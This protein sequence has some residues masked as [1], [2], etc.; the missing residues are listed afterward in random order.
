M[1]PRAKKISK[2]VQTNPRKATS[3]K[4]I[5]TIH[6]KRGRKHKV[7]ADKVATS[8]S[9]LS[10]IALEPKIER[11]KVEQ[12][13]PVEPTL[14]QLG[15]QLGLSET[16]LEK[17]SAS[18]IQKISDINK[19]GGVSSLQGLSDLA[20]QRTI[21]KLE[22]HANLITI[23]PDAQI[24]ADLIDAGFTNMLQIVDTA[25]SKFVKDV[26]EKIGQEKAAAIHAAASATTGFLNSILTGIRA[27]RVN[28]YARSEDSTIKAVYEI[29]DANGIDNPA[30]CEPCK[31]AVSPLAYLNDLLNYA[32]KNI[33]NNNQPIDVAFLSNTFHQPFQELLDASCETLEEKVSQVRICVEVLRRELGT[34]EGVDEA[35]KSYVLKAY[36]FLLNQIGTSYE[37]IRLAY[38]ADAEQQ[39][40][41]ANRLGIDPENLNQLHLEVGALTEEMLEKRF[42]LQSTDPSRKPLT[43]RETPD[44]QTW[45][46]AHLRMLW[47]EQDWPSDPYFEGALPVIDPDI[48]GQYDIRM[49]RVANGLQALYNFEEGSGNTIYDISGIGEA[50]NLQV[51][52]AS[53]VSWL[54][55]G[56]L[57]IKTPTLLTSAGPANKI[58]DACR[59]TNEMTIETWVKPAAGKPGTATH[60]INLSKDPANC[61]FILS[62]VTKKEPPTSLFEVRLQTTQTDSI[63]TPAT[64]TADGSAKPEL[65]HVVYIRRA[66]G[67]VKIYLNDVEKISQKIEG[68][69]SNWDEN[70]R[71]LLAND[72][73][74]KHPWLGELHLLAVYDRALSQAEVSQNFVAK[75]GGA[76]GIPTWDIWRARRRW[77]EATLAYLKASHQANGLAR[78]LEQSLATTVAELERLMTNI[79]K[80]VEFNGTKEKVESL[81]LTV[82]SLTRL[83]EIKSNDDA[84]KPIAEAQWREVYEIIVQAQKMKK[85]PDWITEERAKGIILGPQSFWVALKEPTLQGWLSPASCRQQWQ[86]ALSHR[87]QTPLL[88]P[89][90]IDVADLNEPEAGNAVFDI[91]ANRSNWI[92]SELGSIKNTPKQFDAFKQLLKTV[93]GQS[94]DCLLDH[95]NDQKRGIDITPALDQIS[96]TNAAFDYLLRIHDLVK[97]DTTVLDSEWEQIYDILLQVRKQ[98]IF[99][100]WR[101]KERQKSIILC[102]DFFKISDE[103]LVQFLELEPTSLSKW[104]TNL[105]FLFE[106]RN[107]LQSRIDQEQAAIT[108]LGETVA[109]T[110]EAMLPI[111]RDALLNLITTTEGMDHSFE[112]KENWVLSYLLIDPKTSSRK[113]TTRLTEAIESIQFLISQL[114][115]KPLKLGSSELVLNLPTTFNEDWNRLSSFA[116]WRA[117]MSVYLYP[118]NLLLPEYR[119]EQF[120]TTTFDQ[121]VKAFRV[122]QQV[123]SVQA[124]QIA[125]AYFNYFRDIS[126]LQIEA[127]CYMNDATRFFMFGRSRLSNRVY[128]SEISSPWQTLPK[129][130]QT[131]WRIVPGLEKMNVVEIVGAFQ[132]IKSTKEI[133]IY[134][135]MKTADGHSNGLS[136]LRYNS[137]SSNWENNPRSLELPENIGFDIVISR[138]YLSDL[139]CTFAIRFLYGGIWRLI[140]LDLGEGKWKSVDWTRGIGGKDATIH[141]IV[142]TVKLVPPPKDFVKRDLIF[143]SGE[144]PNRLEIKVFE[145]N[146]LSPVQLIGQGFWRGVAA[147]SYDAQDVAL[148]VFWYDGQ[149][150]YRKVEV[151]PTG[152]LILG[153]VKQIEFDSAK[154][155]IVPHWHIVESDVIPMAFQSQSSTSINSFYGYHSEVALFRRE[156][157]G[158][159]K[160]TLDLVRKTS[161]RCYLGSTYLTPPKTFSVEQQKRKYELTKSAL[162]LNRDDFE[163][164]WISIEEAFYFVPLYVAL[165]LQRAGDYLSALSWYRLIYDYTLPLQDRKVYYGLVLEET[166]PS[167]S[168]L[169]TNPLNPHC[170]AAHRN[171]AYT[172]FTILSLVRCLLG[173]ADDEFTRDTSESISKARTLYLQA[174]EL[175][176]SEHLNSSDAFRQLP[177]TG[178]STTKAKVRSEKST[179]AIEYSNMSKSLAKIHALLLSQPIIAGNVKNIGASAARVREEAIPS[180]I[181]Q[182]TDHQSHLINEVPQAVVPAINI[183]QADAYRLSLLREEESILSLTTSLEF[184][185][186][187]NPI[188]RGLRLHAESNLQKIRNGQNIAGLEREIVPFTVSVDTSNGLLIVDSN[189]LQRQI[190]IRPTIY[191]YNTLIERAKQ[192]V[193]LAQQ[194]EAAFLTALERVKANAY[195]YLKATQDLEVAQAGLRLQDL[196]I[197]EAR[198][199]VQLSQFQLNRAQ[200]QE[201]NYS[202]LIV[203]DLIHEERR[204]LRELELAIEM[205]DAAKKA[206]I[207]AGIVGTASGAFSGAVGGF[208]AGGPVGAVAGGILGGLA[209]G[210][211]GVASSFSAQAVQHQLKATINAAK[212]SY[213]RRRQEWQFQQGLAQQDIVISNQQIIISQNHVQ[214]VT[215]ERVIAGIQADHAKEII[216]FL[217]NQFINADLYQWMSNILEGVYR[218]FLQEATVIAQLAANQ[219]A[220]ERQEILPPFI[221]TDYWRVQQDNSISTSTD[222]ST[223]DRRGLTGSARLLQDIFQLDQYAFETR[224]RK[225]QLTKTISL[226]S[227]AAIEFQ[228]FRETGVMV[229]A[230]PLELFDRDFPGHY[231]RLIKR[232]RVSVIALIPPTDGI[233]ATLSASGTSRVV[234]GDNVFQTVPII[235]PPESIALSSPINATGL[236]EL[237]SE[238]DI[239]FPFEGN[240]V[241]AIWQFEMPKAA[242]HFDYSTIA[243]VL[244]TIEYTALNSNTYRQQVIKQLDR[245]FSADMPF[246]FRNEFADKWYELHNPE[247]SDSPITVNF[248]T[249]RENFPPNIDNLRIQQVVLYFARKDGHLF[250]V[251]VDHLHFTEQGSQIPVGGGAASFDGVISTRRGNA[252]SWFPMIGKSPIGSWELVFPNTEEIKNRFKNEEIE[253]ILFVITYSGQTP[254]WPA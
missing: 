80:G 95:R 178:T 47:Q 14:M 57:S 157:N 106:W 205:Q 103:N 247:Q 112:V 173:F 1:K 236:F 199:G 34:R 139:F 3:K 195:D 138:T 183:S 130:I 100:Q 206:T 27:D 223:Q 143:Y 123:N 170:I 51:T 10:Q 241:D 89:D 67:E 101:D 162:E 2:H 44:L 92:A 24:N 11:P 250:E 245:H 131:P 188:I 132:F 58:I 160:V 122:S 228:R 40:Q 35:V 32:V 128:W 214:V 220:F 168:S 234:I 242:N 126:S 229:F 60:I 233:H 8:A 117:S 37:E 77:V 149:T 171:H 108:S 253:D 72:T 215:Q 204:H 99:A 153:D 201:N 200:F 71:L 118:E 240:G 152:T 135:F 133:I 119:A 186:P 48:I 213:E 239:L 137:L 244:M 12:L 164:Y 38:R 169:C 227:L 219:L 76:T 252:G 105:N 179:F 192:L 176:N 196:R 191:R 29:L 6:A 54:P 55:S 217:N 249:L 65:T 18:N 98:R 30:E 113:K 4:T 42:G 254:A 159:E 66:S 181:Q 190:T 114:M 75:R 45:Q 90:M 102:S 21:Q 146:T 230:T 36:Q 129:P 33:Q 134:L 120:R 218:F 172:H 141:S 25:Q 53:A 185:I 69:F 225:L 248:D 202:D 41:L 87:S 156:N 111:L 115:E 82:E 148:F 221:Q 22:A 86:Q 17:L 198:S 145:A 175:L 85:S 97:S 70:L 78:M 79:K 109:K 226:S 7:A 154:L 23:N 167:D 187:P 231:L 52:N 246:S 64:R 63:G 158:D 19:S 73:T 144:M 84:K 193:T 243:D 150:K 96:L 136:Y 232:V 81:G 224:K 208:L 91:L 62:L 5:T 165:Q 251:A 211:S 121:L 94:V 16:L 124:L 235:R 140:E 26:G 222:N 93:L 180:S 59:V 68:D 50:L 194:I 182:A 212:A 207:A 147:F 184:C 15:D 142:T 189:M 155:M 43:P 238:S 104:R 74:E 107:T 13:A 116:S 166:Q 163:L 46:L 39:K 151:S 61:N 56:G 216:D 237:Q 177:L 161:V 127:T 88:D 31:S 110:E 83:M 203:A 20:D 209:S 9:P 197:R 49:E 210:A 125:D 174:L 28:G